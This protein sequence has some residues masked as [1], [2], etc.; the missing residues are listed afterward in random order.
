MLGRRSHHASLKQAKR[1]LKKIRL[2]H[3]MIHGNAIWK[4]EM[5]EIAKASKGIALDLISGAYSAP[6][7]PLAVRANMLSTMGYGLRPQNA[8]LDEKQRS[9]KVLG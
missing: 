5:G 4:P 1:D 9:A 3:W 6:Y 8:D 2:G 7:E